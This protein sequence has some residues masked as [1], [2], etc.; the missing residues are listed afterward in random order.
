MLHL[1][2]LAAGPGVKAAAIARGR[3]VAP[4][5]LHACFKPCEPFCLLQNGPCSDHPQESGMMDRCGVHRG[6]YMGSAIP[7]PSCL[8]AGALT[9]VCEPLPITFVCL[10]P[11]QRSPDGEQTYNTAR[12][13][14][15]DD[16]TDRRM[17]WSEPQRGRDAPVQ[18]GEWVCVFISWQILKPKSFTFPLS[19]TR[20]RSCRRQDWPI[21]LLLWCV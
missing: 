13:L 6:L 21:Y 10:Q 19:S 5:P 7:L 18:L 2:L 14:G 16:V 20:R 8:I 9:T 1:A 11:R 17:C 12:L 3:E 4:S 15:I